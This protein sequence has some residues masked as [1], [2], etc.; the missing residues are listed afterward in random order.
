LSFPILRSLLNSE[1]FVDLVIGDLASAKLGVDPWSFLALGANEKIQQEIT[2][3]ATRRHHHSS[4]QNRPRATGNHDILA[5]M[6]TYN[7]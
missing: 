5:I 3:N 7:L 4:G 6:G 1:R 2:A